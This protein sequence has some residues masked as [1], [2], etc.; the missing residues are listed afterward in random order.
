MKRSPREKLQYK[1]DNIMSKGTVSLVKILF[2]LTLP[3]KEEVYLE[4][5]RL[6]RCIINISEAVF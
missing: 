5:K 2:W 1:I 6:L 4:E 3:K